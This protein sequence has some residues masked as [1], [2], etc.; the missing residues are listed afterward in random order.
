MFDR[1]HK[2]SLK[3]DKARRGKVAL[4]LKE[5]QQFEVG[6]YVV[7]ID[8]GVGKFGGLV[9]VPTN[10]QMQEMIKI[11]YQNDDIVYVSIHALNKV[12]KYK[13]KDGV[14]RRIG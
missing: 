6:D 2:Y 11:L 12:S 14:R 3:S 5:I 7:H 1:Y 8:H 9:R 4:T 13:G 10:G